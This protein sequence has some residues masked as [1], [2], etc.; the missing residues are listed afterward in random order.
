MCRGKAEGDISVSA[1]NGISK[2]LFSGGHFQ[3]FVSQVSENAI[4]T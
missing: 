2:N 1:G 3:K 4:S